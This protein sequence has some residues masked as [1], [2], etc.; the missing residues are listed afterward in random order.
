MQCQRRVP[1]AASIRVAIVD[2]RIAKHS[3]RRIQD[4]WLAVG[5][6]G[7][8]LGDGTGGCRDRGDGV[9]M[10]ATERSSASRR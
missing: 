9:L 2:R 6:V 4:R 7:V 5:R 3:S 8:A 10:V 1:L